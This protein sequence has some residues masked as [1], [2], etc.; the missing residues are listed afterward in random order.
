MTSALTS[1]QIQSALKGNERWY[2][3]FLRYTSTRD[4]L[5]R[6]E[7]WQFT[8]LENI[9]HEGGRRYCELHIDDIRGE[10]TRRRK[11]LARAEAADGYA[12]TWPKKQDREQRFQQRI[13][14]V[15]YRWPMEDFVSQVMFAD[16]KSVSRGEFVCQCPFP[17]HDDSSP[18]FR[19]YG[20]NSAWCFGCQRG[21]DIFAVAEIYFRLDKFIDVLKT[22]EDLSPVGRVA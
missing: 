17:D 20:N 2:V 5:D 8:R 10:L 6:L 3:D 18:S 21:G 22:L 15:K 1:E 9:D 11:F 7:A 13:E 14:A 19:V 12:P 4:L 16:L